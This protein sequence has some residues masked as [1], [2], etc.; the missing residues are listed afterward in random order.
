MAS[1]E[2]GARR[3]LRRILVLGISLLIIFSAGCTGQ[4]DKPPGRDHPAP[5]QATRSD[6]LDRRSDNEPSR[7]SVGTSAARSTDGSAG[8]ETGDWIFHEVAAQRGVRFTYSNGREAGEYAIL[9][10]LG[11]GCAILDYDL[12]GWEDVYLPG[13]GRLTGNQVTSRPGAMFRNLGRAWFADVTEASRT[14]G[15]RYYTHAAYRADFDNDGFDDLA[16][17]GY[18]GIQLLHNLGDG[19]FQMWCELHCASNPDW[20]SSL[21][22]CDAD[23]DGNLD[24]YAAHYVDWSWKKHP[25][26]TAN[27]GQVREVC[28][29]REFAGLDDALFI[30]DGAGQFTDRAASLGMRPGGKGLGVAAADLTNDGRIDFYVANDTTDNYF[31]VQQPDG[32]LAE[33]AVLAGVAGDEFGVSTGSM[34]IAVF[35]VDN[36][37][38][39]DLLVTNFER[40]LTALYRNQGNGLFSY[41]SRQFGLASLEAV[42][43]GFGCVPIDFDFDGDLDVMIANGH[44]SYHSAHAPFRQLPLL[45]ENHDGQ[46]LTRRVAP[47]Y[48]Q[49]GHT[50]RGVAA[51]DLDRDGAQDLVVSHLDEPAAILLRSQTPTSAHASIR[52]VGTQSNRSAIGV[53]VQ[54][55]IGSARSVRAL[56]GGG[57]YLS[58]G[59][60]EIPVYWPDGANTPCLVQVSWPSGLREQ[61]SIEPG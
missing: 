57:S 1:R 54:L 39:L 61:C 43:V 18:G 26:C 42:Y 48:W 14:H 15:D 44:V 21:A 7:D 36:D 40:E 24:L 50:G 31:Y 29:P 30:S 5:N 55:E 28:A 34:G 9:E 59:A 20:S 4:K 12:D 51:A 16:I 45:L 22:W 10:S 8:G 33:S 52:F 2:Q 53:M 3:R 47:G 17:S 25:V 38:R 27:D 23:A 19:T 49:E 60:T 32:T 37:L 58:S 11:G 46:R 41:A 35:D 56:A 13:G 6:P